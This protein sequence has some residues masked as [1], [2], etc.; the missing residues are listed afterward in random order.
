MASGSM[1]TVDLASAVL[2]WGIIILT[3]AGISSFR[4]A[5]DGTLMVNPLSCR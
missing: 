3:K 4:W 1:P 2:Y 5:R